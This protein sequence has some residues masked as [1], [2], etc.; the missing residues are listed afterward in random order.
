M[1]MPLA[2]GLAA[3]QGHRQVVGLAAGVDR[4]ADLRDPQADAEVLEDGVGEGELVAVE[5][6][7]RLA[8]HHRVEA[9]V[10][11]AQRGE[12]PAGLGAALPGQRTGDAGIEE[13][14]D[15]HTAVRLDQRTG[16]VELPCLGGSDVLQARPPD[17]A[18]ERERD[19]CGHLQP[20][21]RWLPCVRGRRPIMSMKASV[22]Q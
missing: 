20:G 8:D 4:A 22:R 1:R 9:A 14:L 13:L 11:V 15:N 21:S 3:E 19:H 16:A 2:L 10:G 7:L 5:R 18:V 17:P 6:A 12:Q